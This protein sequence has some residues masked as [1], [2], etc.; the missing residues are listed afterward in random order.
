MIPWDIVGHGLFHIFK[1]VL[2]EYG[3]HIYIKE[4]PGPVEHKDEKRFIWVSREIAIMIGQ[5][6]ECV[7]KNISVPSD[8]YDKNPKVIYEF[9]QKCDSLHLISKYINDSQEENNTKPPKFEI[10]SLD[11]IEIM[12]KEA[13]HNSK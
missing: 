13:K 6:I 12:G 10:E 5:V 1:S 9:L 8:V 3:N 7:E 11:F 4:P 2:E